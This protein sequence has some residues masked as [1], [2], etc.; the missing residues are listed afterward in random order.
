[1]DL[2]FLRFIVI[3]QR[4]NHLMRTI[5]LEIRIQLIPNTV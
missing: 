2:L 4:V 5:S 3:D 1:M